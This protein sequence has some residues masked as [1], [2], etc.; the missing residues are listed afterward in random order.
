[1]KLHAMTG[2]RTNVVTAVEATDWRM[3]RLPAVPAPVATTA[4]NFAHPRGQRRQ[5]VLVQG[6]PASRGRY[7]AP[8]RARSETPTG[9]VM[10]SD[11][12]SPSE[13]YLPRGHDVPLLRL[14]AGH[15]PANYHQRSNVETTFS[16]IKAKFG[17]SLCSK[18]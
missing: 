12:P 18:S 14:Q 6:Q 15:L 2:V 7:W 3:A 8:L 13:R 17:G 9:G 5:G 16:M 11:P 10:T 4:Q 1:M